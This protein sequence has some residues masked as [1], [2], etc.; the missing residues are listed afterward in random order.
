MIYNNRILLISNQLGEAF[1]EDFK[2]N[3][4]EVFSLG[5]DQN[6]NIIYEEMNRNKYNILILTNNWMNPKYIIHIIPIINN[7]YP[8]VKVMVLSGTYDDESI[9]MWKISGADIVMPLPFKIDDL[10]KNINILLRAS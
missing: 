2:K 3:G 6:L 8:S 7:F 10:I 1:S 4:L 5:V 9:K